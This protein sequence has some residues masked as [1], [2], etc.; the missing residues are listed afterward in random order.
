[1]E[2]KSILIQSDE[3]TKNIMSEIQDDM[4]NA[5]SKVS[6][7]MSEEVIEKLIPIEKK[8]NDLKGSFQE[9]QEEEF[10]EKLEDL[11]NSIK[12]ISKTIENTIEAAINKNLEEQNKVLFSS[13]EDRLAIL[14][15]KIV[16]DATS[17]KEEIINKIDNINLGKVEEKVEEVGKSIESK[18]KAVEKSIK[19]NLVSGNNFVLEK[20]K[21]ID[22]KIE[23]KDVLIEL[24]NK[25]EDSFNERIDNIQEE[26]EWGNKSIFARIFGK[27][28]EQ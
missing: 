17:N 19:D 16:K 14:G 1:M 13:I 12:N 18:T 6:R 28:R 9:F 4:A 8:I 27:R 3:V 20:I 7:N 26:V 10:E 21:K 24:I 23:D 2:E 11:N 5:L 25:M 22:D 15:L